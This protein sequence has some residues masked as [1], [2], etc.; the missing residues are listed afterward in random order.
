[1]SRETSLVTA[2][3]VA[4]NLNDPKVVIVEVDED[5]T[6]YAQGHIENAIAFHWREDL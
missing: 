5:T 3:W 2:D 1:M 6:L 4:A